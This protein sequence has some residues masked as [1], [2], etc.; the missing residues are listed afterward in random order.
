MGTILITGATG[1][2][3]RAVCERLAASGTRLILAARDQSRLES[4]ASTLPAPSVDGHIAVAVDMASDASVAEFGKRLA[5][6]GVK[7][8]GAVL[9]PP[10][11]HSDTDPMADPEVWRSLFQTSFIGPLSVLKSAIA[12]MEP[13][14]EAGR[15]CK[16]VIISGISSVQVLSHYA[17][18][19]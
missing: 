14:P 12:Q 3:G 19:T 5:A 8:Y 4:V 13:A 18:R 11:P 15:R 9:M 6:S 2:I 1:G 16:I 17:L 7:L 10:Q